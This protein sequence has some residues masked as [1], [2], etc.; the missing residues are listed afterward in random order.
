MS[1]EASTQKEYCFLHYHP[2]LRDPT[3]DTANATLTSFALRLQLTI[4]EAAAVLPDGGCIECF[5]GGEWLSQ[6]DPLRR[7]GGYL[8][9]GRP[10]SV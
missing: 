9:G 6:S 1:L 3:L 10:P 2:Y 7:E 8:M 4:R 5:R